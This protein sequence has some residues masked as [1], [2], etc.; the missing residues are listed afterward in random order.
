MKASKTSGANK[1]Q[2]KT[3]TRKDCVAKT[4]QKDSVLKGPKAADKKLAGRDQVRAPSWYSKKWSKSPLKFRVFLKGERRGYTLLSF[5][6]T[7]ERFW[8]RLSSRRCVA[9]GAV[10]RA[11]LDG[12]VVTSHK[13]LR[14]VLT[15]PSTWKPAK[16]QTERQPK[17]A[18]KGA[19]AQPLAD[20]LRS[21]SSSWRS[22][23]GSSVCSG[24]DSLGGTRDTHGAFQSN[25]HCGGCRGVK[26]A[27]RVK[28]S[29]QK[30]HRAEAPVWKTGGG[31]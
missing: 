23:S 14:S 7:P 6:A 31:T 5:K 11:K 17:Q 9:V 2:P 4:I 20:Q 3:Q 25:C 29:C 21:R 16:P 26:R 10:R 28:C 24:H 15:K 12:V 8:L 1:A 27:D 19:T 18:S 13:T 30:A 22:C